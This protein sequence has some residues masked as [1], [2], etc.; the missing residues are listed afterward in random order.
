VSR[1]CAEANK[2][3][4]KPQ[5]KVAQAEDVPTA[6]IAKLDVNYDSDASAFISAAVPTIKNSIPGIL[7]STLV[8]PTTCST[9]DS[10]QNDNWL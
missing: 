1:K 10:A 3:K 4:N 8:L 2:T 6:Q 5:A 9:P 7:S